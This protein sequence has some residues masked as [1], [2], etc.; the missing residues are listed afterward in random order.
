MRNE[1]LGHMSNSFEDVW[2]LS[3]PNNCRMIGEFEVGHTV[4]HITISDGDRD[5]RLLL[6]REVLDRLVRLSQQML[7]VPEN[8]DRTMP[9]VILEST[10]RNGV[11]EVRRLAR[12]HEAR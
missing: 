8:R 9:P 4:P 5:I 7:A 2:V 3:I 12:A 10:S 6:E 11:Q 1:K